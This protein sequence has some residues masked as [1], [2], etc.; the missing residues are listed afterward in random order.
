MMPNLM[1]SFFI[2]GLFP[3]ICNWVGLV[4][5]RDK[6]QEMMKRKREEEKRSL[7]VKEH[8]AKIPESESG[9]GTEDMKIEI[10]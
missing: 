6:F 9:T 2:F 5:P 4:I 10:K 1:V 8:L 7:L 3:I